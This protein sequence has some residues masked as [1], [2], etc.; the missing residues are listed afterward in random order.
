MSA[1]N[2]TRGTFLM[3]TEALAIFICAE[4]DIYIFQ[5]PILPLSHLA[6]F[7]RL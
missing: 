7:D 3:K 6:V 2:V 4:L 5:I 1:K